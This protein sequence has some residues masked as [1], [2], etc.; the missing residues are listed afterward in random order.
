MV[1]CWIGSVRLLLLVYMF[2]YSW[3]YGLI[4]MDGRYITTTIILLLYTVRRAVLSVLEVFNALSKI[5]LDMVEKP[6]AGH[7][8]HLGVSGSVYL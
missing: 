4:C 5:Y 7:R 3:V 8:G 1:V 2:V 6:S